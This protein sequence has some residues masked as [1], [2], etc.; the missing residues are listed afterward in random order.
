MWHSDIRSDDSPLEAGMA[1]TCKLKSGKPF[2]GRDALEKYKK[3]GVSKRLVGFTL[4]K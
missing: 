4:D 3:S 2:L 1:F